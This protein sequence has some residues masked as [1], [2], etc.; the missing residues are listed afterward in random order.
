V[1]TDA[2][3]GDH[4]GSVGGFYRDG[5]QMSGQLTRRDTLTAPQAAE[6]CGVTSKTIHRWI[7]AGYFPGAR[8]GPGRT[9]G[10]R[11]PRGEV[12]AFVEQTAERVRDQ[13]EAGVQ[14]AVQGQSQ[15]PSHVARAVLAT[16][17]CSLLERPRGPV[18]LVVEEDPNI[19]KQV[20]VVL[21]TVGLAAHVVSSSA[22]AVATLAAVAPALVVLSLPGDGRR[23]EVLE[24]LGT[25]QLARVRVL[26]L[27]DPVQCDELALRAAAM[28]ER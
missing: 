16:L 24:Q 23:L 17:L 21:A 28:V 11:I 4:L 1:L 6:I 7:K 20:A 19:A 2:A 26:V 22:S 5:G 27:A 8:K 9:S 18:V 10:Y 15:L 13:V 25:P 3:K 12:E 14:V